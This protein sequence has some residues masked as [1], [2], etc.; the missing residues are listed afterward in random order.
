MNSSKHKNS[1]IVICYL[2]NPLSTY[3]QKIIKDSN[4]A[5]CNISYFDSNRFFLRV[6][7]ICNS[8]SPIIDQIF[9]LSQLLNIANSCL[10]PVAIQ[11]N[12][13]LL[14]VPL[15]F[16]L[17][18]GSEQYLNFVG[19]C[20]QLFAPELLLSHMFLLDNINLIQQQILNKNKNM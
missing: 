5:N 3:L 16:K 19:D 13:G 11:I 6:E 9:E 17:V 7:W 10:V 1:F 20:L 2:N 18:S 12:T 15:F 4:F 14:S 8:N